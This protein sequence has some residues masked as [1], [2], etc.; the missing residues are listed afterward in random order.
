MLYEGKSVLLKRVTKTFRLTGYKGAYTSDTR[1]D[2]YTNLYY[3]FKPDQAL[4]KGLNWRKIAAR[5]LSHKGDA[6]KAFLADK[7][8]LKT[9]TD[10]ATLV[11]HYDGL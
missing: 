6:L 3:M 10:A 4:T 1:Y 11:Q 8:N 2:A 9:E 7:L 5:H